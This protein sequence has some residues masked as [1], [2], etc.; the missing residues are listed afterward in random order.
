MVVSKGKLKSKML[1]Y[2]RE[3]ERTGEPL[4]VTDHG[5]EVLEIRP[6]T[7]KQMTTAEVLAFYRSGATA[8]FLPSEEELLRPLAEENWEVLK[9]EDSNPW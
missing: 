8:S 3:V 7:K 1:E 5:R 9:V 6:L 4:V 2:F